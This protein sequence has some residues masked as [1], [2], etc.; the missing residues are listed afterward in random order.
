MANLNREPV[1]DRVADTAISGE[2][3]LTPE[4]LDAAGR[5]VD[6]C[7]QRAKKATGGGWWLT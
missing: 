1:R 2:P 7:L 6:L 3:P 5:L 4:Q